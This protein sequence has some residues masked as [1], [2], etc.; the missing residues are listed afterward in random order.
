MMRGTV[1]EPTVATLYAGETERKVR[2]VNAILQ[3]PD[4]E[5]MLGN[6]DREIVGVRGRKPGILEIK[7]PGLRT[8]S[9]IKREGIPDYYQIQM[10]HYLAVSGR[11][12]GAFAIFNAERWEL[13]HFDVERDDELIA[14]IIDR[15]AAFWRLVQEGTPPEGAELLPNPDL[16]ALPTGTEL[17]EMGG[18]AWMN[19][20]NDLRTAKEILSEA[21][22][23][24]QAAKE[25][26]QNIM[27]VA[28]VSTAEGCGLRVYW[29][30]QKGRTS[31]DHRGFA[32][33]HPELSEAMKPYYK[34]GA[35]SRPFRPY[36]LKEEKNHE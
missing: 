33:K 7:C 26:I 5:W 22:A 17:A 4:H 13:L 25:R 11:E 35:A 14:M 8:F 16:P 19:A 28:G 34:T 23:L 9:Q 20:V 1:L 15:D 2:R 6:I 32:R 31:F 12:W 10:Q 27:T 3:H 21:E 29:N 36:F 18:S 24:E 30:E